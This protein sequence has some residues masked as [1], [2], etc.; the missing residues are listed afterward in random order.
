MAE[1]CLP[2]K[3]LWVKPL[4]LRKVCRRSPASFD[5]L[6]IFAG[7]E[8]LFDDVGAFEEWVRAGKGEFFPRR[9]TGAAFIARSMLMA[10]VPDPGNFVSSSGSR[11]NWPKGLT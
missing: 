6:C 3:L 8:V 7:F 4:R 1:V 5:L 2:N 10:G 11:P 9:F